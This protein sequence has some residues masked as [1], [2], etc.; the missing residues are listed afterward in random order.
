MLSRQLLY[1]ILLIFSACKPA[2]KPAEDTETPVV[3]PDRFTPVMVQ[4]GQMI[5]PS[6]SASDNFNQ[7]FVCYLVTS[8]GGI[9]EVRDSVA[10]ATYLQLVDGGMDQT[11]Q[12][13]LFEAKGFN[14]VIVLIKEKNVYA[15]ILLDKDSLKILDIQFLKG[16]ATA[17]LGAK[18][19]SFSQQFTGSIINFSPSNFVLTPWDQEPLEGDVQIDGISGATK[20]CRTSI[21][22]LNNQLPFYRKYFEMSK[23]GRKLPSSN[24]N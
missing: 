8:D 24:D 2:V 5:E 4:I 21:D 12:A 20:I 11:L 17:K 19:L 3:Q 6:F 22:M 18:A 9:A 1:A 14:K 7:Y 23:T 16:S 15:N 13:P 10:I